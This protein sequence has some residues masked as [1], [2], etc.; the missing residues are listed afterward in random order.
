MQ[1]LQFFIFTG[2]S[3]NVQNIN[4]VSKKEDYS[5][6][7]EITMIGYKKELKLSIVKGHLINVKL[8]MS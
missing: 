6:L 2:C 3:V 4:N 8:I 7:N 5:K 1:L